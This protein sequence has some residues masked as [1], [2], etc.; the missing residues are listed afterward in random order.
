MF[1]QRNSGRQRQL[2]QRLSFDYEE[3]YVASQGSAREMIK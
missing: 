1:L 2:N 3:E